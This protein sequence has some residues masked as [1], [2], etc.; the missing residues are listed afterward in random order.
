M[1][2]HVLDLSN[3]LNLAIALMVLLIGAFCLIKSQLLKEYDFLNSAFI[4][5][6]G[7]WLFFVL[8]WT[9]VAFDA[10]PTS[11]L[12]FADIQ[13]IC[14]LCFWLAFSAGEDW[15]KSGKSEVKILLVVCSFILL[16]DFIFGL[17]IWKGI[18][19][20]DRPDH[21]LLSIWTA[22]SQVL[23]VLAYIFLGL[24]FWLRYGRPGISMSIICLIYT[25]LQ[26]PAYV[27]VFIDPP[28]SRPVVFSLAIGK[29][30]LASVFYYLFFERASNY[31]RLVILPVQRAP[32]LIPVE[33]IRKCVFTL[34]II[35]LGT[36]I[37]VYLYSPNSFKFKDTWSSLNN[38]LELWLGIPAASV[39]LAVVTWLFRKPANSDSSNDDNAPELQSSKVNNVDKQTIRLRKFKVTED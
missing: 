7:Q 11:A 6:M 27:A 8:L 32:K 25:A 30:L 12:I 4:F 1:D 3:L 35:L 9:V 33:A 2:N 13:S 28:G 22:P 19:P 26:R 23:S 14:A 17:Y 39:L 20:P 18:V 16:F 24:G 34:V 31:K 21:Q 15:E 5:W 36:A 37:I 38:K 29:A 10:G